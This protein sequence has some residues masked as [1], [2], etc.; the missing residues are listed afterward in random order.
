MTI[1][2]QRVAAVAALEAL[3][4]SYTP[5]QGWLPPFPQAAAFTAEADA[6]HALLVIRADKLMGCPEESDS[7]LELELIANTVEAYETK[8]WP[9]GKISGGKG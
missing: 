5:E 8:R 7:A 1:D 2:K 4:F 9:K 3:G 6:M